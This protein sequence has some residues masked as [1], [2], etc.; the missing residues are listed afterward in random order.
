MSSKKVKLNSFSPLTALSG[1]VEKATSIIGPLEKWEIDELEKGFAISRYFC[2]TCFHI[3][4][5]KQTSIS[6][7][8]KWLKLSAEEGF[9]LGKL[10]YSGLL[11]GLN[12]DLKYKGDEAAWWNKAGNI[13]DIDCGSFDSDGSRARRHFIRLL[14]SGSLSKNQ[15]S[16][17]Y[18][19][20]FHSSM[21]EV[22]LLPLI[23]KY[24]IKV[25]R[26]KMSEREREREREENLLKEKERGFP[27]HASV[28]SLHDLSFILFSP[29]IYCN[30][31]ISI[32][33]KY[34]NQFLCFLPLLFSLLPNLN[35]IRLRGR[36]NRTPHI[37]LSLMQQVDT[38]KLEKIDP[39]YLF[40]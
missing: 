2:S 36:L 23:S 34:D 18:R 7:T 4:N 6:R 15:D 3:A 16:V 31:Y 24:L 12:L 9:Q 30:I 21:R 38:S 35:N 8:M 25:K 37:D 1:I 29:F 19:S 20:F 27:F 5:M 10:A 40:L 26:E 17:I 39:V 13:S 11:Y 28:H 14:L 32:D 33:M 22:H